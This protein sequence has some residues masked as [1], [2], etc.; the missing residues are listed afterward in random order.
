MFY[1]QIAE[2]MSA[3]PELHLDLHLTLK[4][5][6]R[7]KSVIAELFASNLLSD[8]HQSLTPLRS[9]IEFINFETN[10]FIALRV[11]SANGRNVQ[12]K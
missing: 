5:A 3:D 10:F 12:H 1:R 2:W 9:P 11:L 4:L 6:H 8:H 7:N